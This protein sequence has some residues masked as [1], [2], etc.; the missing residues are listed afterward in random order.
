MQQTSTTPKYQDVG[1]GLR[2]IVACSQLY[3]WCLLV[4]TVFGTVSSLHLISFFNDFYT[5]F[6]HFSLTV[7]ISTNRGLPSPSTDGVYLDIYPDIVRAH[8]MYT[9][10][11]SCASSISEN[12]HAR[13]GILTRKMASHIAETSGSHKSPSE[14]YKLSVCIKGSCTTCIQAAL[15]NFYGL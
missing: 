7:N 6:T 1:I 12:T 3:L 4:S 8:P 15:Y 5:C 2:K 13:N 9:L 11:R 10:E 14:R